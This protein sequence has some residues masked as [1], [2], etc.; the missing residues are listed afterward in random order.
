MREVMEIKALRGEKQVLAGLISRQDPSE[1]RI[2]KFE[3]GR[4]NGSD[5]K[6]GK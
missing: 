4:E 5:K 2:T 6:A 1:M 3:G